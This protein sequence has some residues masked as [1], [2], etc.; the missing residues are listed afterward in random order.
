MLHKFLVK[1]SMYLNRSSELIEFMITQ[2][3]RRDYVFTFKAIGEV[4]Q[5][6]V[7]GF[8]KHRFCHLPFNK[9]SKVQCEK[10]LY[11]TVN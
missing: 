3:E 11:E 4:I 9:L 5:E 1:K 2:K 10:I 8:F 7:D 6:L